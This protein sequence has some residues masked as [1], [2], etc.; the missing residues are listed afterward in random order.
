MREDLS[1]VFHRSD[2]SFGFCSETNNIW[3]DICF[4]IP[5]VL[6]TL[7]GFVSHSIK[8]TN[9][10]KFEFGPV[11]IFFSRCCCAEVSLVNRKL[12]LANS[13]AQWDSLTILTFCWNGKWIRKTFVCTTQE[14]WDFSAITVFLI[15]YGSMQTLLWFLFYAR[16]VTASLETQ[17]FFKKAIKGYKMKEAYRTA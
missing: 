2:I 10:V 12:Q 17:P 1:F 5:Y 16:S 15:D 8:F 9:H 13:S 7:K 4:T 14:V 11:K 3:K 6:K